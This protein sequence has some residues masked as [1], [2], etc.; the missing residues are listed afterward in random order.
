MVWIGVLELISF[1]FNSMFDRFYWEFQYYSGVLICP[2]TFLLDNIK[3][4]AFCVFEQ[5]LTNK[6]ST[7]VKTSWKLEVGSHRIL[8]CLF[9]VFAKL[10]KIYLRD[11]EQV[12]IFEQT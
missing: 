11:L 10:T 6:N 4:H 9:P 7:V 2:C 1:L 12:D 3:I 8:A 5:E